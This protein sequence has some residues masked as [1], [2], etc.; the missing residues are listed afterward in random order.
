MNLLHAMFKEN[1]PPIT[2]NILVLVKKLLG[3]IHK[4]ILN[5]VFQLMQI[6]LLSVLEAW[7]YIYLLKLKKF[8]MN[9]F[10]LKNKMKSQYKRGG[11]FFC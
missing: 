8:L 9:Y 2:L 6:S 1:I 4:I 7:Y 3:K 11:D 5:G 10:L